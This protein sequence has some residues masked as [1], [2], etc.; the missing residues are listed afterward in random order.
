MVILQCD[1]K[2]RTNNE[3]NSARLMDAD[4]PNDSSAAHRRRR[5]TARRPFRWLPDAALDPH[6][7]W[8]WFVACC[9]DLAMAALYRI[10]AIYPPDYRLEPGTLVVSNHLRD[11]DGPII[12]S[13]LCRR[14]KLRIAWPV[15]FFASREDL[16]Q[17]GFLAEYLQAWPRLFRVLAGKISL[18]SFLRSM[19]VEPIRRV[20]EYTLNE[21]FGELPSSRDQENW[22]NTRGRN[23]M[24][25]DNAS[26]PKEHSKPLQYRHWGL[27]RLQPQ[28]R[29]AL[30][31]GFRAAVA[32]QLDRLARRLD[33]GRVVYMAAEGAASPNGR[34]GRIRAGAW[35]LT[36]RA[37]NTPLI[38]PVSVSYDALRAGRLRAVVQIGTRL[39][40]GVPGRRREFDAMLETELRRLYPLTTSHLISRYLASGPTTFT[41]E[42]FADWLEWA[43][44]QLTQAGIMLAP[45]LAHSRADPLARKRLCWLRRNGLVARSKTGWTNCWPQDA[46]AGWSAPANIVRYCENAL[47]D[48]LQAVAPELDLKP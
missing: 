7:R 39:E 17:R 19:R 24:A 42:D 10:Q 3:A 1:A 48:H 18:A 38:Q 45:R 21:A 43:R 33:A 4:E 34:F 26:L 11:A 40:A 46:S 8:T 5:D 28:A 14:T 41:T 37:Q 25:A 35:E 2:E 27:R 9:V 44:D 16:F 6:P 31:P 22:L 47:D 30:A 29:E 13:A 32:S 36:Q 23:E 12:T 15:P 20:P